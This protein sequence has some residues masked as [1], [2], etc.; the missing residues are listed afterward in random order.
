M[1]AG[2]EQVSQPRRE[3][4]VEV[5]VGD[6][7]RPRRLAVSGV[8]VHQVDVGRVVQLASAKFSQGDRHKAAFDLGFAG[9]HQ[10]T[11]EA[12]HEIAAYVIVRAFEQ[13]ARQVRQ[14]ERDFRQRGDSQEIP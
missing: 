7:D 2:A 14:L 4:L 6:P 3:L 13:C 9:A 10:R 5:V 12:S 8:Q 11:A 1:R